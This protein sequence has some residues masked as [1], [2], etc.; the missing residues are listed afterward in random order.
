MSRFLWFSVYILLI[1]WNTAFASPILLLVSLSHSL[2]ITGYYW[3]HHVQIVVTFFPVPNWRIYSLISQAD[4]ACWYDWKPRPQRTGYL[5]FLAPNVQ[6]SS[7][8][9][10]LGVCLSH[11]HTD[12]FWCWTLCRSTSDFR[13][14][15]RSVMV[16]SAVRI[17]LSTVRVVS[18]L[19]SVLA[20][21]WLFHWY[22]K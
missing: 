11:I 15:L 17:E 9:H 22:R 12:L 5:Q 8:R 2:S 4:V 18:T 13:Q 3:P 20:S 7:A 10:L 6:C 1:L 19:S 14:Y 16:V 21:T